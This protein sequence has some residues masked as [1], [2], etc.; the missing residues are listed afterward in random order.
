MKIYILA[1]PAAGSG[2]ARRSCAR[3]AHYLNEKA[4]AFEFFY[5]EKPGQEAL[6]TEKILPLL[7][8]EDRFII[9]GGDGTL[10]LVLNVWPT[11]RV[12]GFIS[13]GSGNDFARG[14]H[15]SREPITA[16]KA[17]LAGHAEEFYLMRYSGALSGIAVNNIGIGLDA[18]IVKAANDSSLKAFLNKIK[19][20]Q[21]SYLLTAFYVLLHKKSF[22]AHIDHQDFPEAFLFTLTKHPYFGGGIKIAPEASNQTRTIHLV[23]IDKV[24]ARQFPS[25]IRKV[26][27]GSQLTD[28]RVHHLQLTE[29][30]QISVSSDQPVQIDG[31][32]YSIAA[33]EPLYL[34]VEKR[35][36]LR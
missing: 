19:L 34:S 7:S 29:Q 25:L 11:D 24:P 18:A 22:A 4:L 5:T 13:A 31:E 27:S 6:L 17:I 2:R 33:D 23:E 28:P 1:N 12:F 3:I 14:S 36:I 32:S 15:L 21:L 16:L 30:T 35:T 26:L 8:A 9:L 20:G 10:S